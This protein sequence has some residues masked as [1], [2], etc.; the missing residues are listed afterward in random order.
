MSNWVLAT[1]YSELEERG[2]VVFVHCNCPIAVFLLEDGVYAID[3]TC[4]HAA[5]S[6]S[7]GK[8]EGGVVEC[9]RHGARFDIRTGKNL[10][11]PA[12][13]PVRSY[14]VKVEGGEVYV[15]VGE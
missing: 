5:V 10:C 1:K 6:L 13:R 2:V 8:V 14:P 3:D 4:S 7:G 11:F 12:V 15:D 9:P